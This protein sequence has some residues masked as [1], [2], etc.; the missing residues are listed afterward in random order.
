MVRVKIVEKVLAYQQCHW[1][2]KFHV[3]LL[4][5]FLLSHTP[6]VQLY[7]MMIDESTVYIRLFLNSLIIPDEV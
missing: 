5:S 2:S 3:V 7:A 6:V 1:C 4:T